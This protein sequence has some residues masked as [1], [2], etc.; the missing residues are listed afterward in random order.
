M[1]IDHVLKLYSDT[2]K[3]S[4]L[5]YGF[6]DE[7]NS[8]DIETITLQDIKKAQERYIE[9][10]ATYIPSD[11]KTILD[12]G[13]GIGGNADY[14]IKSG[15]EIETL[16]PDDFQ[17]KAISIKFKDKVPFHH[18]KFEKFQCD[19]KYDLILESESACYINIKKGFEKASKVLNDGGYLLASDYFV[20]FRD[21]SNS[22]HLKS[23][24]DITEY[25]SSAKTHGFDIIQEYD[26]TENTMLTLDCGKYFVDRFINPA[27]EYAT[28]SAKKNYPKTAKLIGKIIEPKL[29]S[30]KS[31][32]E[33]IDSS[34]FR[35]YRKY[36]IYLF[37]KDNVSKHN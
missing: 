25:L 7:P 10:L 19:K 35:K 16:S 30:K 17:K 21:N 26:Q 34:Q 4:Y 14:L 5:H 23:S 24:H 8:I 37:K 15:Y 18:C 6:W 22:P 20:H 12:V 31:Q 32:L 29:Q 27:I 2:I 28:Y 36:M 1:A 13:C 3:S 33:L 9:H 11:V